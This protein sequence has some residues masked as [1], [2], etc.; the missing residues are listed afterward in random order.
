M[1]AVTCFSEEGFEEIFVVMDVEVEF[2]VFL[3]AWGEEVFLEH[4]FGGDIGEELE[5]TFIRAPGPGSR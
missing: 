4:V 5:E 1:I 3:L 2:E